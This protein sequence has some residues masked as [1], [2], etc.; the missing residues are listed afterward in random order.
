[1]PKPL[2]SAPLQ[3]DHHQTQTGYQV[4]FDSQAN[5]PATLQKKQMIHS[6]SVSETMKKT[7]DLAVCV[8]AKAAE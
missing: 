7:L 5:Y 1:M 6:I 8:I 3:E 2:N 4:S